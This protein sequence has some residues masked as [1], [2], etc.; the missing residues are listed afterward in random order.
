MATGLLASS[1]AFAGRLAQCEEALAGFVDWPVSAVLRGEPGAPSLDRVDVVQPVL[2]AMM[3][4]LAALWEAHGVRPD[5]VVGHSQ[6][7]I[8]AACVSGILSLEDGA[9]VAAL[10]SQAIAEVLGSRGGMLSA[11]ISASDVAGRLDRWQGRICV[12]ADNGV[13]SVVLSG[14][15]DALGEL[16]AELSADGIRV[17]RVAVDYASHSPHVDELRDRLLADLAPVTPGKGAVPMMSAVTG[18]WVDGADLRADYWFA[19]LRHTVRFAPVVREL[20]ERG[21]AAFVEV[22]PHPVLTMS[23]SETLEDL[24]RPVVVVGTLRRDK[25]GLGQFAHAAAE[26]HVRGVSPDWSAFFPGARTT[27]LPTYPFQRKRYWGISAPGQPDQ[28]TSAAGPADDGFWSEV[29]R[30]DA[31]SLGVRLG[32]DQSALREVIPAL[33][34]WRRQQVEASVIDSWRYRVRW[35]PLAV[36]SSAQLRGCWLLLSPPEAE[37]AR[38]VAAGLA[39]HGAVVCPVGYAVGSHSP[40]DRAALA[41]RIPAAL[42]GQAPAGVLYLAACDTAAP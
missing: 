10:R 26:L 28:V 21:H 40:G 41:E 3:V 36:P 30:E 37:P 6:G 20:A 31:E 39:G 22:S 8:A 25:G 14:P 18:G 12:A 34:A 15:A 5:A 35:S 32:V 38:A 42:A 7:E 29:Q 23:I 13:R 16:R 2:W 24:D 9:R 11:A 1:P 33:S 17:K 4:S 19:N 27:D